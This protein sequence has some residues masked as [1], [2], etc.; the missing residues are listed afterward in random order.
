VGEAMGEVVGRVRV[1]GSGCE[2]VYGGVLV[3]VIGQPLEEQAQGYVVAYG[4]QVRWYE[5]SH[6]QCGRL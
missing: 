1:C 6:I 2:V 3:T 4:V 5:C